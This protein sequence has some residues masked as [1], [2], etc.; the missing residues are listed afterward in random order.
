MGMRTGLTSSSCL[1]EGSDIDEIK[2]A[3]FKGD[4]IL[5]SSFGCSFRNIGAFSSRQILIRFVGFCLSRWKSV[6]RS[7]MA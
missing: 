2:G 5:S 7:M 1:L 6:S 3:A 4:D